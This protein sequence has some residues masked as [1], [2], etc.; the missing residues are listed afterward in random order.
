MSRNMQNTMIKIIAGILVA[1]MVLSILPV[2]TA[3]NVCGS[4]PGVMRKSIS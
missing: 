4:M 2:F 1:M 3:A